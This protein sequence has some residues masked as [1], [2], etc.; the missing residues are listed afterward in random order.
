MRTPTE[1]RSSWA[2]TTRDVL[3]IGITLALQL[4]CA[5]TSGQGL[6]QG[7]ATDVS[8]AILTREHAAFRLNADSLWSAEDAWQTFTYQ[9]AGMTC[10]DWRSA[11]GEDPVH[12]VVD[13]EGL[14]TYTDSS[15]IGV[16][17]IWHL[18]IERPTENA[19]T[20]VVTPGVTMLPNLY[21]ILGEDTVTN[22]TE[23]IGGPRVQLSTART[24]FDS[25]SGIV[26][27]PNA[28]DAR[29]E[30]SV[31]REPTGYAAAGVVPDE[32][33]TTRQRVAWFTRYD[34][35]WRVLR[36]D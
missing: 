14:V 3:L 22:E 10:D 8:P 36:I 30:F 31:R 33:P 25:I 11:R 15:S 12:Q 27:A 28:M 19:R 26:Q 2:S 7:A 4:G 13:E 23:H 34:D 6:A 16:D 24:L 29:V 32:I 21:V 9:N 17:S 20:L 1:T 35:G 5:D 18:C